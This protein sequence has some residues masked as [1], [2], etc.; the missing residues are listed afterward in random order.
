MIHRMAASALSLVGVL[1]A[2][3]LLLWKIGVMGE[4]SCTTSGCETVQTSEYSDFLGVPVA[5]YGVAGF[6]TLLIVGLA[7]LQPPWLERKEPTLLLAVF[8]GIGVACSAYLT[9]L[10]AAVIHAWCQWCVASAIL[11]T[12]VFA[13]SLAGLLR[14]SPAEARK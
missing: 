12:L 4:L 11:I 9:Y 2:V 5:L 14:W 1:V 7:G 13:V 8:S 6:L 3:Y 10:E